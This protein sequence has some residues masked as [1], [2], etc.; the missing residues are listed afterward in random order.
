MNCY[1][2]QDTEITVDSRLGV[3]VG[4]TSDERSETVPLLSKKAVGKANLIKELPSV[5]KRCTSGE[6]LRSRSGGMFLRFRPT[7]LVISAT[8]ICVGFCAVLIHP[9]K[10]GEF[11]VTIRRCLFDKF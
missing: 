10:V 2:K 8:A 6:V 9:H 7:L 11:A 5:A 1:L 4:S 3:I